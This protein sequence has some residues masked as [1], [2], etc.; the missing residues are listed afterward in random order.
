MLLLFSCSN[1]LVVK[2]P[3]TVRAKVQARSQSGPGGRR[4][5][6]DTTKATAC[7]W[8]WV[9]ECQLHLATVLFVSSRDESSRMSVLVWNR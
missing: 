5:I 9:R 3:Y 2:V 7:H 1:L 6:S 4:Q 8:T